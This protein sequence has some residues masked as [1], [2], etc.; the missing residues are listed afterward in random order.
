MNKIRSLTK[1][2]EEIMQ[3]IW[4]R[5][6]C[7]VSDILDDLG[8]PRQPHSS[9]STIVRILEKKDFVGHKA[10]GRTYEYFPLISKAQYS[11]SRLDVLASDYFS[12]SFHNMVSYLIEAESLD[13]KEL[14]DFI[15]QLK[16]QEK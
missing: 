8:E 3:L 16:I 15:Q 11:K 12:G 10:F 1:A 5:E 7:K 14:E 13:A 6:R 2:E 4:T 9:V